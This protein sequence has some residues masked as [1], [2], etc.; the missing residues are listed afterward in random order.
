MSASVHVYACNTSCL[1]L[2]TDANN[3]IVLFVYGRLSSCTV[4]TTSNAI[5]Y[6]KTHTHKYT[7]TFTIKRVIV[8]TSEFCSVCTFPNFQ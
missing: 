7:K 3:E 2:M 6:M 1:S 4:D 5:T 8:V